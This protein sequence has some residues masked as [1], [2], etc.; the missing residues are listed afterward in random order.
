MNDKYKKK[1]HD[2]LRQQGAEVLAPTNPYE[3]AR[4]IA[5]G[6]T[7][8][9]YEGRRG[10]SANGFASECFDAFQAGKGINMG[11]TQKPRDNMS[12]QRL[13]LI[14]RDGADCFFCRK[15]LVDDITVEHLVSRHKGGPDH[16]DNLVLA[17][18]S[19]NEKAANLPLIDK[20][21]M[22]EGRV[23]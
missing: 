12:R 23:K 16:M 21:K 4:F 22:R 6:S 17:H 19:C 1:F 2:W 3:F 15:P 8:I 7:Q 18:I 20:I 14:E 13:A 9:V 10:I 11:F 5:R